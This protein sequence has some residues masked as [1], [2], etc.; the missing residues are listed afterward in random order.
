MWLLASGV[1]AR[2]LSELALARRFLGEPRK[3][4]LAI[5][6]F[7]PVFCSAL[8]ALALAP[9]GL[10]VLGEFLLG[11]RA[12]ALGARHHT[13]VL[14]SLLGR[15]LGG[16]HLLRRAPHAASLSMLVLCDEPEAL[17]HEVLYGVVGERCGVL[18][19]TLLADG[20]LAERLKPPPR[21]GAPE[22]ALHCVW[23]LIASM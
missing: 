20:L 17:L 13:R 16:S 8:H 10:L 9:R 23:T 12:P 4:F 22:A 2:G 21:E 5:F 3:F 11:E 7:F 14:A 19:S 18:D 15:H 6:I 1:L